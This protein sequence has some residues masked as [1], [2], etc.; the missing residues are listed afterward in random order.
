MEMNLDSTLSPRPR[1][2]LQERRNSRGAVVVKTA[3]PANLHR[4]RHRGSI[5]AQSAARRLERSGVRLATPRGAALTPRA[6][7]AAID[8][9]L[10][11]PPHI[12][13]D[14]DCL[15]PVAAH[16]AYAA[17][18]VEPDVFVGAPWVDPVA[19]ARRR[20]ELAEA[21]LLRTQIAFAACWRQGRGWW[22]A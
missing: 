21:A 13:S 14:E 11:R 2:F 12:L 4:E 20:R 22:Q 7:A 16:A 17:L 6:R 3:E 19:T 15:R 10:P 8:T 9:T 5:A 1:Q 18:A